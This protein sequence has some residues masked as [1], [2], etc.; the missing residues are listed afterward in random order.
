M[1]QQKQKYI[2]KQLLDL[3]SDYLI[4]SFQYTTATGFS[5]M[6]DQAISHDKITRFLSERP[7]TSKDL[8]LLVK[9]TIRQIET[10]DGAI[11]FDDTIVEKAH[12][13]ENEIVAWHYDHSNLWC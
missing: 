6:M 2:D 5:A 12:T 10:D 1:P 9:P 11:S 7:Y 3:Y 8:W 4:S 13:D